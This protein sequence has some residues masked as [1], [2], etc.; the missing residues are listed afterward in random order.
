MGGF[1]CLLLKAVLSEDVKSPKCD[2]VP[3]LYGS[4]QLP[5]GALGPGRGGEAGGAQGSD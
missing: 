5:L 2:F 3:L 4:D 1:V